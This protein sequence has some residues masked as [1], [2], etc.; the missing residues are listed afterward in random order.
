MADDSFVHLHL[1]TQYS[2]LDGAV[3][4]KEV[5]GKAVE[6]GMPA[7]AMTDHGNVFGAVDFYQ[8]L[9]ATGIKPIIGCELYVAPAARQERKA[10][11]AAEAAYHLTVLAADMTGYQNLIKLVSEAYL[12]GFY[13][14]PRVD[15][16]LLAR[17]SSGIICLSG[18]LQGEANNFLQQGQVEKA[19]V[20]LAE[21]RDIFGPDNFFVELHRHGMAIQDECNTQLVQ[22][23]QDLGLGLV[24]ANDVHF[25]ERAHHEAHDV[26]ICIGTGAMVADERRMRYSKELYFK[27][28]QEMRELFADLP[29]A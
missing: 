23:A 24:A 8:E 17:H 15:K 19:H 10:S 29:V 1:H 28:P 7:V 13:Y 22:L 6:Y 16:E 20:S 2:V 5:A 27:S 26:M 9:S 21:Y 4:I 25:L 18:C 14:R 3:R 11:S 12:S